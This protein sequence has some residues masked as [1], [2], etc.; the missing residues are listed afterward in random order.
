MAG[1]LDFGSNPYAGL[2]SEED[3]AGARR[4]ATTD[5]LLK[6]SSGLF[7]AGAPSRTPQSLGRLCGH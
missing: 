7:Q 6:L 2:L 1:L 3:L 4:Q 5:A